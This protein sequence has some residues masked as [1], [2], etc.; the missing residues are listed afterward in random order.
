MKN[1]VV[2][3][4]NILLRSFHLVLAA[5][6]FLGACSTPKYTYYFSNDP[7]QNNT[8]AATRTVNDMIQYSSTE[9]RQLNHFHLPFKK[10]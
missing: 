3:N 2:I 7:A 4:E 9:M 5:S 8:S 1:S 10:K 6:L